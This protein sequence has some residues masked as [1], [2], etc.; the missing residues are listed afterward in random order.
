[1]HY[2]SI[3][4]ERLNHAAFTI[5][6]ETKLIFVDPF[7][8]TDDQ[9]GRANLI[10]VTHEHFDHMDRKL[11][12]RLSDIETDLVAA[13]TCERELRGMR[14]LRE[15]FFVK[16]GDEL[17]LWGMTIKAVAA[18][19][20]NKWRSPG[21]PFHPKGEARVGYVVTIDGVTIYH[22]GDADHI[23][24]MGNL[25]SVDIALL[26]VSGTYVM[27]WQEA[28]EAAKTI[29]PKLAIP[30]HYGAM[31]GTEEDAQNFKEHAPCPT[32]ILTPT[33]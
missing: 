22:A 8:L 16:P 31:V 33:V 4:I 10:V 20:I 9:I 28:V 13:K 11:I 24:E 18:Y 5:K 2:G 1:M 21:R 14:V 7:R 32:E 15:S 19:N 3:E 6:G 30:M 29:N 26:P 17:N 23:T 25:G 27:T 12:E